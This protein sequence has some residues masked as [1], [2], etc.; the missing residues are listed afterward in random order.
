[1]FIGELTDKRAGTKISYTYAVKGID[2]YFPEIFTEKENK[3]SYGSDGELFSGK[4]GFASFVLMNK[5]VDIEISLGKTCFV[6]HISFNQEEKSQIGEITVLIHENNREK[7]VGLIKPQTGKLIT[8][9][10]LTVPLGITTDKLTL[11]L[12]SDYEDMVIGRLSIFGATELEDAVYPL[13]EK[14]EETGG[15]LKNITGVS[16]KTEDEIFAAKDFCERYEEKLGSKLSVG[17]GNISFVL[18]SSLDEEQLDIKVEPDSA[19]ISG[20]SRRALVYASSKLIQLC[21]ADG[22]RTV[23]IEDKP[24]MG[25]RGVHF[26]LPDRDQI[27]FLKRMVKYVFAPMGYNTVFLQLSGAMEYKSHPE[28]NKAWEEECR[29]YESGEWPC[30]AHYYFVGHRTLSQEEVRDLCEYIRSFGLDIVPEVQSLSHVQYITGAHPEMG[31]VEKTENEEINLNVADLKPDEFYIHSMC[32]NHPD[33][34]KIIFDILDEVIDVIKPKKYVHIGHD[35]VYTIG[36]CDI[37]KNIPAAEIYAKEV[38]ALHDHI[39]EKGLRTMM[40]S[41][42]I[43]EDMYETASAIDMIPKDIICLSFTWYFHPELDVEDKL[44]AHGFDVMIG[45]LYSSHY[46]RFDKRKY[47][48]NLIGA[49]ISTWVTCSEFSYGFEGKTYDMIYTANMIWNEAFNQNMRRTYGEIVNKIT[50]SVRKSISSSV[51]GE[52]A[53]S[54]DFA[55]DK[56][57]VPWDIRDIYNAAL[58]VGKGEEK[59]IDFAGK[60][61]KISFLHATDVADERVMWEQAKKIGAYVIEYEDGTV[62]ESE[63]FYAA[64]ILRYDRKYAEPIRSH[65]FRHEGYVATCLAEPVTGKTCEGRDYTL[66]NYTWVNPNPEKKIAKITVKNTAKTDTAILLFDVKAE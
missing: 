55:S 13:P 12:K 39:K 45:N 2:A 37:C 32:P 27:G 19:V 23:H 40:W 65:L 26:A 43:Q 34:Y 28:V 61:D 22:I 5:A 14:I 59:V 46:Q 54:I 48:K 18:D 17:T 8:D 57:S 9:K 11:R 29:K 41:D 33:Y 25:I 35:E 60:A 50:H 51:M 15:F 7:A 38:T 36:K 16:A 62:Q 3:A 20:G 24:F 21:T 44:Y 52:N 30:P 66:Y 63:I 49:E 53:K 6:D 4:I 42:M 47:G 64:N 1:M 10:D 31:E 58:S 56:K